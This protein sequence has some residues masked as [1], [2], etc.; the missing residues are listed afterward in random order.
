MGTVCKDA[1]PANEAVWSLRF[2]VFV[3]LPPAL[4]RYR[5]VPL[6][7]LIAN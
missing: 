6:V 4:P 2:N 1:P 3:I 7:A 5:V